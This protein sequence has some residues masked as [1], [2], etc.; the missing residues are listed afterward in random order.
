MSVCPL[1]P[2]VALL[3]LVYV[4]YL[5]ALDP[6]IGRPSLYVTAGISVAAILYYLIVLRRR[7]TW[8]LR[9]PDKDAA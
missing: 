8:V 9:G 3:V 6:V 7:G 5:N 4:T 1:P 2:I